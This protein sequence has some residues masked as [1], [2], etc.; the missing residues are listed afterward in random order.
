[1]NWEQ[2]TA[3]LGLDES[4]Y[5]ELLSLFIET[6]TA[7]FQQLRKA[8]STGDLPE[9]ASL[10]HGLK[11][12]AANLGLNDIYQAAAAIEAKAVADNASIEPESSRIVE[13]FSLIKT[14]MQ[15]E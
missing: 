14:F 9:V 15:A 12:T 13:Q 11:G 2:A 1:M 8:A 3:R 7:Q 6:G 4:E 10:A 5:R